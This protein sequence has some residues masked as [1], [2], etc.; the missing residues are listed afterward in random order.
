MRITEYEIYAFILGAG[1][2]AGAGSII[3]YYKITREQRAIRAVCREIDYYGLELAVRKAISEGQYG[4]TSNPESKPSSER[5]VS[6]E[7]ILGDYRWALGMINKY[8][9]R[10]RRLDP[11]TL[12]ALTIIC[13]EFSWAATHRR[14][15]SASRGNKPKP[16]C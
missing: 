2:G 3:T 15:S 8:T 10:N 9:Q 6:D 13:V 1:L 5:F 4:E 16:S 12:A 7:R 14:L 11:A